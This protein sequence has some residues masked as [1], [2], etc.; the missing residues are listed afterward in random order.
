MTSTNQRN[1][2][3]ECIAEAVAEGVTQKE[4]CDAIEMNQ[5]TLQRWLK[6]EVGDMRPHTPHSNPKKL[7]EEEE[8]QI[9]TVSNTSEFYGES[10]NT[11]VPRLA[12]KGIY[13]ASESTFYRV[14]KAHN[15]LKHRTESKPATKRT[16]PTF[17]ATGPD[18]VWSWDITYL[19]TAVRGLF[20]YLY[21]FMDVWS[22]EIVGWKIEE[23]ES[24][25]VA[26]NKLQSMCIE[27]GIDQLTLHSDNGSPMKCATMLSR[28]EHLGVLP[29]FS[30]PAVSNDN[31][32]SESL[33]KTLKYRP[34]Y[35][36]SFKT[37]DESREWVK[38][39]VYW[40]NHEHRHSGINFVTPHERHTG[41]DI[42]I[43]EQRKKTYE[44]AY[45][46]NPQRWAKKIKNFDHIK[47]VELNGK[48]TKQQI[49]NIA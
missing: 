28:M 17:T 19:K 11:I 43:L 37:I 49:K 47:V 14:L 10:P 22:R 5:R 36:G 30:R 20:F 18:Q 23:S 15:Q 44:M 2:I 3:I 7:T 16:P 32:F 29:S 39:F 9:L 6:S 13:I 33:F 46:K 41:V 21:L 34:G 1:Q 35:P 4:A 26:A 24:G 42:A 27:R 12:E 45:L 31:P 38:G 8:Q 25:E 40:Y 48:I